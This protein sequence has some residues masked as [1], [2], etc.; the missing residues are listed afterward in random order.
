MEDGQQN[1][2]SATTAASEAA[3]KPRKW[4]QWILVY[5]TFVIALV[6]AVPTFK[7][8]YDSPKLLKCAMKCGVKI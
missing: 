5:P 7:E 4:W 2:L 8:L 1:T 6:G 3:A